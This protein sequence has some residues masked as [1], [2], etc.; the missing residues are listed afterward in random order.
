M[1]K[2]GKSIDPSTP[3]HVQVAALKASLWERTERVKSVTQSS[4]WQWFTPFSKTNLFVKSFSYD[5]TVIRGTSLVAAA[6]VGALWTA[7]KAANAK[8]IGS[9]WKARCP[10]CNK[11]FPETMEHLL[12]WCPKWREERKIM[13]DSMHAALVKNGVTFKWPDRHSPA[14][15]SLLLGG[16][17]DGFDLSPYWAEG[18]KNAAA[19]VKMPRKGAH[20]GS[21]APLFTHVARFLASIH[22]QRTS[23]IWKHYCNDKSPTPAGMTSLAPAP[24]TLATLS[25]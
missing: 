9:T 16:V 21:R 13:Y 17:V 19:T 12:V 5:P 24:A 3:R 11:N 22:V 15:A 18:F 10:S 2:Q 6:R 25:S 8:L 23:C 4:S 7:S 14:R 20:P 1:K